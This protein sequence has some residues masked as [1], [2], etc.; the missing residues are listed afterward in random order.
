MEK[1][2][3]VVLIVDDDEDVLLSAELYLS[4]YISAIHTKNSPTDIIPF[5]AQNRV[6]VVMLDMNYHRGD[7]SGAEGIRWIQRV[8]ETYPDVQVI[9]MTA[10]AEIEL[11]VKA[12]KYGAMDFITKPWQNEKLLATVSTG[13]QL[14]KTKQ[15][16]DHLNKLKNAWQ[17]ELNKAPVL[18]AESD[19]MFEILETI[20]RVAPT[21]A[22]VLITGENGTGKEVVAHE[23][24]KRSLRYKEALVKVDLGTIPET[25]FESELFGARKGA[26]TDLKQDKTGR[27]RM[28]DKGTL[29][30]DEIANLPITL[31]PKLLSVLQNRKVLPLGDVKQYDI[32]IRLISATNQS[33]SRLVA[34][35]AFREDL[36]Y[37]MN[38][39]ELEIPALRHRQQDIPVLAQAFLTKYNKKYQKSARIAAAPMAK[40]Q[41]YAWP[42]NVR[43]LEHAIERAVIMTQ[44][45]RLTAAD[46]LP[47]VQ[48]VGQVLPEVSSLKEME[49]SLIRNALNQSYGS[50]TQAAKQLGITRASLYRRIEK[51]DIQC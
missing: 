42:G 8:K 31:Q 27:L 19:A 45:D 25:L 11:A 34:S 12:V 22:N 10:Y 30:L 28:A 39:I 48:Q 16:V 6:E 5:I 37:R 33:I 26:Y 47:K 44:T 46:V 32:D 43:E 38:T 18:V 35:G 50:I 1:A 14:F 17:N 15:E 41:K 24:H 4:R 9:A 49:I 2:N 21:D 36:L 40:L 20:K 7:N 13:L 29:F 23:I 51:Y 3:G